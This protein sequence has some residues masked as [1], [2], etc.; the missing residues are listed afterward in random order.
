MPA[1]TA[2]AA[3]ATATATAAAAAAAIT[4]ANAAAA[5]A[6][7]AAAAAAAIRAAPLWSAGAARRSRQHSASHEIVSALHCDALLRLL[8]QFR[9][10]LRR[11]FCDCKEG[12]RRGRS[13][14]KVRQ[15]Q[16]GAPSAQGFSAL[17]WLSC[18]AISR[19]T[20]SC[21]VSFFGAA[22]G[23]AA[24]GGPLRGFRVCGSALGLRRRKESSAQGSRAGW[25]A[26]RTWQPP[27]QLAVGAEGA[28]SCARASCVARRRTLRPA[29]R[30]R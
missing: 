16:W 22:A 26:G 2:A 27:P 20:R 12:A 18:F 25:Q 7:T 4:T 13:G 15:A 21:G 5:A 24:G 6:A 11:V 10:L 19:F 3:A 1:I 17:V 8:S 14:F 28:E 23:A 29:M 30:T 9:R